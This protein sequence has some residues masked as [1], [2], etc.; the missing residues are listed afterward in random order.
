MPAIEI[1]IRHFK[2]V[3]DIETLKQLPMRG[4]RSLCLEGVAWCYGVPREPGVRKPGF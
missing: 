2:K 4:Y 1:E 3:R